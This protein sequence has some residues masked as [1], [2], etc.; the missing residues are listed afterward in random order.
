MSDPAPSTHCQDCKKP[1]VDG[2][3]G[4]VPVCM[5]CFAKRLAGLLQ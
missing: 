5:D 1:Q 2:Y 3:V 4:K